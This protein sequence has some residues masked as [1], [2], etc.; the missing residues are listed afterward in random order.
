M[1]D[2]LSEQK[3]TL[4]AAMRQTLRSFAP[5]AQATASAA[6]RERLIRL[7][8]WQKAGAVLLFAPTTG[9]PDVGPLLR[10]ALDSGK[11][12][13]LPRFVAATGRYE[14]ARIMDSARDLAPGQFGILEPTPFCKVAELKQ[15]D[16]VLVP[17]LAFDGHGRRLGRGKGFYD[18]L[19]AEVSGTTCGVAFDQQ[20]VPALPVESHDVHLNCIL[21]PSHWLEL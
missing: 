10:V 18:R 4:R 3:A 15:L 19:L 2:T 17:A 1:P 13:A 16:L 11:H 6:I 7:P 5:E 12:V 21:T 8:I 20:L 9:E 14:A